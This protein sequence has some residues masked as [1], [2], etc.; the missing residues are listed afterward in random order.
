MNIRK[1]RFLITESILDGEIHSMYR[2]HSCQVFVMVQYLYLSNKKRNPPKR[3]PWGWGCC[4]PWASARLSSAL[5]F[6]VLVVL[7]TL[8]RNKPKKEKRKENVLMMLM[9][10]LQIPTID[11]KITAIAAV[12]SLVVRYSEI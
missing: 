8:Y 6:P 2:I 10:E 4:G 5:Y 12:P 1:I 7:Y 11:Q 9:L 3:V